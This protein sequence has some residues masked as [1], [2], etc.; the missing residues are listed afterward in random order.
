MGRQRDREDLVDVVIK[1]EKRIADLETAMRIG[2]TSID[3]GELTVRGGD[4]VIQNDS[5]VEVLRIKQGF[6]PEIQF[7]PMGG[8]SNKLTISAWEFGTSGSSVLELASKTGIGQ[9]DGGKVLL[10]SGNTYLSYQ[11]LVGEEVLIA[12]SSSEPESIWVRGTWLPG[13]AFDSHQALITDQIDVGSGWSGL[14]WG[15]STVMS[16]T[17]VPIITIK[18]SVPVAWCITAQDNSGGTVS[19]AGTDPKTVN[20]WGFRLP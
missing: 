13:Y 10:Y 17:M 2:N 18:N 12:L 1:L 5:G 14:I 19:W 6:I 4:I 9:Q 11:P 7:T 16:G 20:L 3:T 15:Y 8:D